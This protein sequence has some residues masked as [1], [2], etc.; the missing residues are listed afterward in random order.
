M[1]R[2]Q[3]AQSL[4]PVPV[5]WTSQHIAYKTSRNTVSKLYDGSSQKSL[6]R[7]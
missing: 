7:R 5:H 1:V 4:P 3:V 6:T 2:A